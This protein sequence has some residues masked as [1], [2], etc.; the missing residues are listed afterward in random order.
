LQT[1]ARFHRH[2][3][4]GVANGTALIA[5]EMFQA[6]EAYPAVFPELPRDTWIY[7]FQ[8]PQQEQYNLTAMAN[9]RLGAWTNQH[10]DVSFVHLEC[11]PPERAERGA[12]CSYTSPF[13][14]IARAA[15]MRDH[16]NH[17]YIPDI[18]GNVGATPRFPAALRSTSAPMKATIY[19]D[20]LSSRTFAWK[21]FIPVDT[22]YK[23]FWG[24]MEYFIGY[25]DAALSTASFNGFRS[26]PPPNNDPNARPDA[27][28]EME[29]ATVQAFA[30]REW[31]H[32][33]VPDGEAAAAAA[34][35]AHGHKITG[36]KPTRDDIEAIRKREADNAAERRALAKKNVPAHDEVGAW[37]AEGGARWA[38]RT[39]RKEDALVYV[40]RLLLEYARCSSEGRERM[41]FV[42]DLQKAGGELS[43]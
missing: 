29:R 5:A 21:H 28:F 16:F 14:Q 35:S 13:Y 36:S 15:S 25:D 30:G 4:V 24:I 39:M 18:D 11:F 3:W 17:K 19:R 9:G 41:A 33:S 40:Y 20:W 22:T 6:H 43:K 27:Q 1:W 42:A 31:G 37:I 12:L 2:R 23:D 10:T 38:Q 7:T 32:I 34:A 26:E 8:L